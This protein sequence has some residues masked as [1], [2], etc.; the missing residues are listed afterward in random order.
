[1]SLFKRAF[2]RGLNDE[3]IRLG[4]AR[5][6]SKYAAD[7]IADAVG[8]QMPVEPAMDAVPA[9]VAADVATTLVD[10]ANQL[11]EAAGGGGPGPD[12]APG[13]LPPEA[14]AGMEEAAKESAAADIDTRAYKQ[15][16]AVMIKSAQ[17]AKQAEGMGST[18][19]GGDKGNEMGDSPQAET[20]M[21]AKNRPD[22]MYVTGVGNT[23]FP[24]GQG[25][26]GTETVPAP[27]APGE[28]P[29]GTNSVIQQSKMGALRQI[30]Q[31]VAMGMGSTI[32][33]GD[34]GNTL[35]DAAGVTG[36]AQ[37]EANRRPEG[38]AETG[39]GNTQFPL[40]AGVVGSEQAHPDQP[41]AQATGAPANSVT[42]WTD[43]NKEGAYLALF[44]DTAQKI[45]QFL[46]NNL[47]EDEK[48]AHIRQMMGLTDVER[49]EYL[50]LMHKQAGATDDQAVQ[51][52]EKHAA[53]SRKKYTGPG[54]TRQ[55]RTK[56]NQKMAGEMPEALK[57][58]I[59]DKS[60]S[61]KKD[62]E[63]KD[64]EKKEDEKKEGSLSF[65]NRIRRVAQ[66]S[67]A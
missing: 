66:Q 51:I 53:C 14:A 13:A 56:S 49:S 35:G 36:E 55:D 37:L 21:E 43:S 34:K 24:V 61:E 32:E 18:I 17:Q 1:M 4:Y 57:A 16:E 3:L 60:D 46:P 29:S 5:Y 26:V 15:A 6:P 25:N 47:G 10:A 63:K 40:G 31:K 11:V 59:G 23:A 27:N 22:M 52:A 67:R 44:Q 39:V 58:A 64:D 41:G 30:I 45:A 42:E 38:Y 7:E 50:G 54:S 65:L 9:E 48:I 19:E 12:G 2:V 62:D 20:K 8:D 33:G 28:S